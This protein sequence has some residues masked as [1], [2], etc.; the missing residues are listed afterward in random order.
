MGELVGGLLAGAAFFRAGVCWFVWWL[1][2]LRDLFCWLMALGD[3]PEGMWLGCLAERVSLDGRLGEV[4]DGFVLLL[5]LVWGVWY[6]SVMGSLGEVGAVEWQLDVA[7]FTS[8]CVCSSVNVLAFLRGL[9]LFE[10]LWIFAEGTR[11]SSLADRVFLDVG[12]RGFGGDEVWLLWVLVGG[13][14]SGFCSVLPSEVGAAVVCSVAAALSKAI[15]CCSVK[16]LVFLMGLFL[17]GF[18]RTLPKGTWSRFV[19]DRVLLDIGLGELDEGTF[20]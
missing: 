6:V 2:F 20:V 12:G 18:L 8:I 17:L 10:F 5:A 1:A 3:L 14:G 16:T 11:L 15:C 19:A 7:A 9:S 13:V 4:G